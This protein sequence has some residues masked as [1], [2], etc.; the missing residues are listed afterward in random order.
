MK[1]GKVQHPLLNDNFIPAKLI[2]ESV[3]KKLRQN[4]AL[5]KQYTDTVNEQLENNMVKGVDD[6]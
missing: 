5:L 6:N 2:L 3:L 4:L 1:D